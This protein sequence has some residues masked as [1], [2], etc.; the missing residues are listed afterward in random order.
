MIDYVDEIDEEF[1][2]VLGVL[3]LL[4]FS[5][6]RV[7]CIISYKNAYPYVRSCLFYAR[8]SLQIS[9]PMLS[10]FKQIS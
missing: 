5:I 6:D 10:E 7:T 4:S 9:L 3:S 1:C 8:N 2:V